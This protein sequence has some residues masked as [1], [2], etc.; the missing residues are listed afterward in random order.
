MTSIFAVMAF[1][2]KYVDLNSPAPYN[3]ESKALVGSQD[4][5]SNVVQ[6][7]DF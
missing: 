1:F 5:I 2:Y 4:K 7:S 6:E 3:E